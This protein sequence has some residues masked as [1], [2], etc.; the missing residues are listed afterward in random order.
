M[1]VYKIDYERLGQWSHTDLAYLKHD[2]ALS[3]FYA[4]EPVKENFASV[5]S[6]RKKFPVNRSLLLGS[7]KKQYAA[8]GISLPY[9]DNV[10]LDENTFTVTT[11]HQPVLFTGPLYHLYKISSTI[12]LA[13]Q[14][15]DDH[16]AQ[17]FIP[18][19]VLGAEDHD[20]AETNHY[21][22]FGKKHEW[23]RSASGSAG[24]LN[25]EGLEKLIDEVK[26]LFKN[27]PKGNEI[28]QHLENA[29]RKATTYAQFHQAFLISL[30]QE[31]GLVVF[32]MD[33]ADLKK[34][35]IPVMEKE[36]TEQF[37]MK[38]VP[39]TQAAL[40]Q[41][42][43]KA[44]A[45][46]R[47]VNLF[48][49][50]EGIRER[51]EPL[52]D[53]GFIR[54]DSKISYSQEELLTELHTHP[55]RFSPN[56]ILRP[57]YQE[58]ILPNLA[59]IGGGGELAYWLERKTQFEAAGV[60][61]PMLIRRNSVL[62]IDASTSAQIEKAGLTWE[63]LLGEYD[64]IVKSFLVAHSESDLHFEDEK[65]LIH[66]AYLSLA[67]KAQRMDP[68]LSSAILAEEVKQSKIFEQLG[69]R[70]MRAEKQ[71]QETNINRIKKLK[72]KLF[73][74]G[75]L[76]ERHDNMMSFYSLSGKILLESLVTVCDPLEEKFT[77]LCW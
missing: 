26:E 31:F 28:H 21:F 49:M 5:I 20:W 43:F 66:E 62:M 25:L 15:K 18:V 23:E 74:G 32:N 68:T 22:L 70:L 10:L 24:R 56:V 69:S 39:A 67:N 35:F 58:S 33:D 75:G 71:Q 57:L 45:Y 40:E 34:S 38:Y 13:R 64:A 9:A 30:Y 63:D 42:G 50:E 77:I 65:K 8:L 14:L 60:H 55:E 27:T 76:Q 3:P 19:F 46:C 6:N 44:Q 51:I 4:Y 1:K 47:P 12:H 37:S 7:L 16:P 41:A 73:P 48:Y 29:F 52:P 53:G 36:L 54:V 59:Y 2:P 17:H 72:D 61:F 11:A